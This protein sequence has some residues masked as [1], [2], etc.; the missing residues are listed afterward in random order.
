MV[1]TRSELAAG[2][3]W[4]LYLRWLLADQSDDVGDGT[5]EP[6]V[7]TGVEDLSAPLRVIVNFL[8]ID[9]DPIAVAAAASPKIHDN[10]GLAESIA[11]LPAEQKGT[12]PQ[13]RRQ[14]RRLR[15]A[16]RRARYLDAGSLAGGRGADRDEA[17][18]RLRPGRD[19]AAGPAGLPVTPLAGPHAEAPFPVPSLVLCRS[20]IRSLIRWS[21]PGGCRG[22]QLAWLGRSRRRCRPARPAPR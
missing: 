5:T 3:L 10:T 12:G 18:A 20:P 16:P 9:E 13:G 21:R 4:L 7:P 14:G 19:A 6:P 15:P 1:Q 22:G 8:E 17:A 2:D 11:S